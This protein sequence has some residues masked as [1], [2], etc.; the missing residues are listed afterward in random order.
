MLEVV[1]QGADQAQPIERIYAVRVS[2]FLVSVLVRLACRCER[3]AS[4][5]GVILLTA[6]QSAVANIN[7]WATLT[8]RGASQV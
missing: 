6:A 1:D 4:R 8:C 2:G 5:G 3:A 7:R